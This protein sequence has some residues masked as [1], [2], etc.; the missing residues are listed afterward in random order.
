MNEFLEMGRRVLESQAL[1]RSLGI[2]LVDAGEG[3][4]AFRAPITPSSMQHLDFVHGGL[5]LRIADAAMSF[6]GG[7]VLGQ[8][9][10]TSEL[11]LNFARPAK[12]EALIA[13]AKVIASGRRQAV[14][15]C[16]VFGLEG[17]L[18]TMVALGQGT[19]VA[20]SDG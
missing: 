1:V 9:V 5:I 6:A 2:E 8:R 3:F 12:G 14:V 10:V 11:K 16:E 13:R 20:A 18:E 19:I 17:G 15:R 7:T 4:T